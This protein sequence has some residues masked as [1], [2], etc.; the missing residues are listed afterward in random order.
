MSKCIVE[1]E[2]KYVY[3]S[4]SSRLEYGAPQTF[5]AEPNCPCRFYFITGSA[6]L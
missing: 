3:M 1:R 4:S 5:S 2:S 6:K